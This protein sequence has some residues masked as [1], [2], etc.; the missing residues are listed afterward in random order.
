MVSKTAFLVMIFPCTSE[1][2]IP[3]IEI[4]FDPGVTGK[5]SFLGIKIFNKST[6]FKPL[7]T[8]ITL[9]LT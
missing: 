3:P 8:S 5:K 2:T 6:I 9:F 1:A 4:Y 7:S